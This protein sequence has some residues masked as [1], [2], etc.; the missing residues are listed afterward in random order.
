[1]AGHAPSERYGPLGLR[2]V[3]VRLLALEPGAVDGQTRL[4]QGQRVAVISLGDQQGQ[5]GL[6]GGQGLVLGPGEG[7]V[8]RG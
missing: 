5:D 8:E 3:Q 1:M 2:A 7:V 6:Q 4:D